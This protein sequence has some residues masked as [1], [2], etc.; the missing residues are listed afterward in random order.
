MTNR[1]RPI[2]VSDIMKR[3]L[4]TVSPEDSTLEAIE[5]MREHKISCLPVVKG[6]TL[7]GILTERDLMNLAAAL[8][9]DQLEQR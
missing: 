2:A 6:E 5:L 4:V 3:D 8:I 9:R 7:V 1:Q